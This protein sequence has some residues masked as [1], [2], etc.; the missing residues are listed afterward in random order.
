MKMK[1]ET[2]SITFAQRQ[3]VQQQPLPLLQRTYKFNN[4]LNLK[5]VFNNLIIVPELS[6]LAKFSYFL[7]CNCQLPTAI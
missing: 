6:L 7:V 2:T 4:V 1:H 5:A 3:K